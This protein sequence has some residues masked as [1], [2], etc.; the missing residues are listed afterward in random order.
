M[1]NETSRTPGRFA[2]EMVPG[3][4]MSVSN[5]GD[6]PPWAFDLFCAHASDVSTANAATTPA[7]TQKYRGSLHDAPAFLRE[8][9][10][11]ASWRLIPD[12][13]RALISTT[14]PEKT[15]R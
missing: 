15:G 12:G 5:R 3:T 9:S 11:G 14:R 6:W 7:C 8:C 13:K 10:R 1:L 2:W 4:V